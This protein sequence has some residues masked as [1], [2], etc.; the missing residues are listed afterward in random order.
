M[1]KAKVLELYSEPT[2]PAF[3]LFP[4]QLSTAFMHNLFHM[5][6]LRHTKQI[7]CLPACRLALFILNELLILSLQLIMSRALSA[8]DT[9]SVSIRVIDIHEFSKQTRR[10]HSWTKTVFAEIFWLVFYEKIS[11]FTQAS[12]RYINLSYLV[13]DNMS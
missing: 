13:T 3:S 10:L 7:Q 12:L 9:V 8:R 5:N 4:L 1:K 6:C 2:L 11:Y